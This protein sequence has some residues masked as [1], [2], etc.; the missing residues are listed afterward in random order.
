MPSRTASY[1]VLRTIVD[2][3]QE[4]EAKV[5]AALAAAVALDE[6]GESGEAMALVRQLLAAMNEE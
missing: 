4:N 1:A 3:L 2:Q 5:R 6:R